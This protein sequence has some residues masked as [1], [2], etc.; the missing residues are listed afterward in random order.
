MSYLII[1]RIAITSNLSVALEDFI[2]EKLCPTGKVTA[3]D[4][5]VIRMA[6]DLKDMDTL[7]CRI[8][9]LCERAGVQVPARLTLPDTER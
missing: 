2:N 6:L 4:E 8:I 1:K 3:W 7:A 5:T 9:D